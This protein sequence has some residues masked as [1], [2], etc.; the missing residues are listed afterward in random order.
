MLAGRDELSALIWTG[1]DSSSS[2]S[3]P[4]LSLKPPV[5]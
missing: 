2:F 5:L 3:K 1:S 4:I